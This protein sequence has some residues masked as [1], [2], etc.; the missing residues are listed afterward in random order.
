MESNMQP[1]H[2]V[3]LASKLRLPQ[4]RRRDKVSGSKLRKKD[5]SMNTHK[6][7]VINGYE[8][9]LQ[10]VNVDQVIR[11]AETSIKNGNSARAEQYIAIRDAQAAGVTYGEY[12][13]A[14]LLLGI[15]DGDKHR[16]KEWLN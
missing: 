8:E 6:S 12:L 3:T 14:R 4:G 10:S 15:T 1:T 2:R 13:R 11:L 16:V 7:T 9:V 5:I